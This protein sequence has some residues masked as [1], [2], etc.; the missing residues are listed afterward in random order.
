MKTSVVDNIG[1]WCRKIEVEKKK[2]ATQ[3]DLVGGQVDGLVGVKPG[4]NIIHQEDYQVTVCCSVISFCPLIFSDCL[5]H[6]Q[7][8]L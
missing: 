2:L 8:L 1:P 4:F 6:G 5:S 7:I 3:L